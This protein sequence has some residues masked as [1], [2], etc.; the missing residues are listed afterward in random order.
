MSPE[1]LFKERQPPLEGFQFFAGKDHILFRTDERLSAYRIKV[2][3][4]VEKMFD[5]L[6]LFGSR[7]LLLAN[8]GILVVD[9]YP[10][11]AAIAPII[12]EG[13]TMTTLLTQEKQAFIDRTVEGAAFFR[14][15]PQEDDLMIT[16]P[17]R[18]VIDWSRIN[19][20]KFQELCRDLLMALPGVKEARITGGQGDWGQDIEMRESI[21]TLTGENERR[22]A[23]QCKHIRS[24]SLARSDLGISPFE[25]S[26]KFDYDVY[27][28]MTSGQVSPGCYELLDM[29]ERK[30]KIKCEVFDGKRLEDL[31]KA[32]PE[33]Y[34]AHF[35]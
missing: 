11:W 8:S 30:L 19:E 1:S 18:L 6:H 32:R 23:V 27:C 9:R 17:S 15:Q 31:L 35:R 12:G 20:T 34:A 13:D 21:R 3:D 26:L 4:E 16:R 5:E 29:M 2:V 28:V 22:W 24:R 33:I 25:A 14:I 10:A 7:Y